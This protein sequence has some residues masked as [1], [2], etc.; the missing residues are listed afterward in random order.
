MEETYNTGVIYKITNT[1][2]GKIYIGKAN[3]YI[4]DHGKLVKHGI[5]GR[6]KDHVNDAMKNRDHCPYFYNAIRKYGSDKFIHELLEILSLELLGTT[7]TSYI[8]K[9]NSTTRAVGYN[10]VTSFIPNYDC[11]SNASRID[12]IRKTMIVKWNNDE[13]SNKTTIANLNA[14]IKRA[15]SGK[16]RKKNT[17]LN[18][19]P[20]I[21]KTD[22]GYD[23]RI[24]RNGKY[25]ITSVGGNSLSDAEKLLKAIKRLDEIRFNLENEIDDS[26]EK[27]VDHNGDLLPSGIIRCSGRGNDGYRITLNRNNKRRHRTFTDGSLTMDEK[28][29]KARQELKKLNVDKDT[30]IEDVRKKAIDHNGNELPIEIYFR[31]IEG[32]PG[33]LVIKDGVTKQ[34]AKA[35]LTL[36]QKL[37][38]AKEYLDSLM[39]NPQV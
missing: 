37:Q 27:K 4:T 14:I 19:P 34:F 30:S 10:I 26:H 13:Y 38:L 35:S 28:L 7:E 32:K 5:I 1:V 23:I 6:F 39:D 16:L 20:N 15:G 36:D 12:K 18:L 11:D 33:Y 9:F 21:Y 31:T 29:E 3:S 2:N 25:K 24:M 17:E 8:I 22:D